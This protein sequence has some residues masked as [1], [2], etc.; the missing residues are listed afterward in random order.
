[1]DVAC[2][3][4]GRFAFDEDCYWYI[5][6]QSELKMLSI[7]CAT[8]SR[9]RQRVGWVAVLCCC[10]CFALYV[11]VLCIVCCAYCALCVGV[12]VCEYVGTGDPCHT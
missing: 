5:V 6:N 10:V 4:S 11:Y 2:P 1:M 3:F 8:R 12:C 9:K 7:V